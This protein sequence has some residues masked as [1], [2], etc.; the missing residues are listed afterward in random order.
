LIEISPLKNNKFEI[1][2]RKISFFKNGLIEA[3]ASK[4]GFVNLSSAE[5]SS[6]EVGDPE[7]GTIEIR[8]C[9]ALSKEM[10]NSFDESL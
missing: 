2:S 1:C 4:I 8:S 9:Y 5:V 7:I 3:G 6:P 10:S